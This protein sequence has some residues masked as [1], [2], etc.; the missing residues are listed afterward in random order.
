MQPNSVV[1]DPSKSL[2]RIKNLNK[3][4]NEKLKTD[5]IINPF[6]QWML[7]S[8]NLFKIKNLIFFIQKS[9]LVKV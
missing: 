8:W 7:S 2:K 4:R 6:V 1:F 9:K 5:L 3:F